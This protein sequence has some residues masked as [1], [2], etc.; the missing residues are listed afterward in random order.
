MIYYGA[1]TVV[2][3]DSL[4]SALNISYNGLLSIQGEKRLEKNIIIYIIEV[5]KEDC[6]YIKNTLLT[7]NY[8]KAEVDKFVQLA[9]ELKEKIKSKF[10]STIN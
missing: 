2:T 6:D 4:L 10:A 7:R 8:E 1:N 5:F 3:P 9:D